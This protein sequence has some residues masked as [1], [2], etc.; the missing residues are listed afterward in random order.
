[1]FF[2]LSLAALFSLLVMLTYRYRAFILPRV[3]ERVK[4]LFPSPNSAVYT[5]LSTF[6]DQ[7]N[8]GLTSESFDIEANITDG[9]SR[10]GL[11]EQGTREVVDIMKRERVNFDQARLIRQ[12]RI[13]AA[14][15]IDPSGTQPVF[16]ASVKS[17]VIKAT[18]ELGLTCFWITSLPAICCTAFRDS[19]ED[20]TT[21]KSGNKLPLSGITGYRYSEFQ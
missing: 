10:A 8:A 13:L 16:A 12:N 19:K 21:G 20:S 18:S 11:D 6:A 5:R 14:N 7:V 15:G 3:P 1:M 9:D 4:N 2:F 17:Q